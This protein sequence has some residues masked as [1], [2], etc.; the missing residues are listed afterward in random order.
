MRDVVAQIRQSF[1]LAA[2]LVQVGRDG[3]PITVDLD[4]AVPMGLLVS[5]VLSGALERGEGSIGP[6][7]IEIAELSDDGDATLV[8]IAIRGP[9][10]GASAPESGLANR[11]IGAYLAQLNATIERSEERIAIVL[12][13][14]VGTGPSSRIELGIA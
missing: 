3:P 10:V 1:G 4:R 8:E 2:P 11:L 5:E 7:R 6:L 9:G 14:E 13:I 12:A